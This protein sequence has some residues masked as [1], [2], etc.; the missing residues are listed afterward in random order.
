MDY[1]K[2]LKGLKNEWLTKGREKYQSIN[3]VG[4]ILLTLF[5]LP[6]RISFFFAR[7]GYWF[8]WF[9][10]RAMSAPVDYLEA[11]IN[12]EKEGLGQAPAAVLYWVAMPFI[13]MQ[14]VFLAFN[15]FAFFF[16]W[17]GLMLT[18]FIMTLGAVRWQ[19]VISDAT[20]DE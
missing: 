6:M 13:F 11:W 19:P 10:Y 3:I 7:L 5:F 2:L 4:R 17:F 20:F 15:A 8:T 1:L 16:Q 18:A 9:F 14:K 12:K